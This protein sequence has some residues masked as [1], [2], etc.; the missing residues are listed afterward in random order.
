MGQY[1]GKRCGHVVFPLGRMFDADRC[2][3]QHQASCLACLHFPS[4]KLRFWCKGVPVLF[5]SLLNRGIPLPV[6]VSVMFEEK[7]WCNKL[8]IS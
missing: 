2:T 5:F 1:R 7:K 6:F 8:V 3:L 4:G